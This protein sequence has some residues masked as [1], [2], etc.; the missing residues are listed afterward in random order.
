MWLHR[1]HL[2][3]CHIWSRSRMGLLPHVAKVITYFF[4]FFICMKNLSL[5]LELKPLNRFWHAIQQQ[6]RIHAGQC[7]LGVR[8]QYLDIFTLKTP[9]NPICLVHIMESPWQIHIRITAWCIELSYWISWNLVGCL[10]LP[11]T[12]STHIKF[13]DP[14]FISETNRGRKLKFGFWYAGRNLR[15]L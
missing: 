11:S 9:Q 7:L 5:D 13:W 1:Q 2:P 3:T 6:T 12:W 4:Y 15:V 14:V 8:T 10:T